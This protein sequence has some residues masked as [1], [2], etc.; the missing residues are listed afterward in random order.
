MQL[1]SGGLGRDTLATHLAVSGIA[2]SMLGIAAAIPQALQGSL[3][4]HPGAL[5]QVRL[6][7]Y[8]ARL[9]EG[10]IGRVSAAPE[11]STICQKIWQTSPAALRDYHQPLPRSR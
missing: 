5:T 11:T 4:Q 1:S 6:R 9:C 7:W 2:A 8:S 10:L 3:S